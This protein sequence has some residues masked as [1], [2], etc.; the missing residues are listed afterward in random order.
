MEIVY[1]ELTMVDKIIMIF[2]GVKIDFQNNVIITGQLKIKQ[3]SVLQ[4]HIN[5]I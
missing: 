5:L 2:H 4:D 3:T 1:G